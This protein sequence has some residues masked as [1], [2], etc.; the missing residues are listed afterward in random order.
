MTTLNRRDEMEGSGMGLTI[1]HRIARQHGGTVFAG[2]D[3][4]SGGLRLRITLNDRGLEP[5]E[6]FGVP[7]LE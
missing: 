3:K 2:I 4:A 7:G 1:V 5:S 6:R